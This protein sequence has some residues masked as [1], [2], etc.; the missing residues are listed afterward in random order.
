MGKM[1]MGMM[2]CYK[3]GTSSSPPPLDR[4][5]EL[6]LFQGAIIIGQVNYDDE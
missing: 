3:Q 4:E 1:G 5:K 2:I 6:L